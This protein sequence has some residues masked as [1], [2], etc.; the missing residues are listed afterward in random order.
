MKS[1]ISHRNDNSTEM[2]DVDTLIER[3]KKLRALNREPEKIGLTEYT[4]HSFTIG[5][6]KSLK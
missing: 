2:L 1:I 6:Q 5:G 3:L 4:W